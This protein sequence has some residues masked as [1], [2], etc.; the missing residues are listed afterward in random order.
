LRVGL[1]APKQFYF[2]HKIAKYTKVKMI[3]TIGAAFDFHAGTVPKA[4]SWI[5]SSGMPWFYR[6]PKESACLS[7]RYFKVASKFIFDSIVDW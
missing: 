1:G 2:A 4:P 7:K 6:L 3:A 5:E